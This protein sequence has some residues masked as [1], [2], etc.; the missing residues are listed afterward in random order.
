MSKQRITAL[1]LALGVTLSFSSALAA[2]GAVAVAAADRHNEARV[3]RAMVNPKSVAAGKRAAF[4]CLYCHGEE[5]SSVQENIPNLA[6]QNPVYLLTQIEKFGDGRRKDEFM[7][8][9]IKSLKEEDRVNLAVYYASLRPNTPAATDAALVETGRKRYQVTCAGCHGVDASGSHAVAR[10]AGQRVSYLTQAL[11]DYRSKKSPRTDPVMTT[12]A[13]NL[14][15]GDI[16]AIAA[17][18]STLK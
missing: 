2:P 17:Y 14:S 7:S 12:V 8:G 9:L 10:L 6:G 4:L 18:L 16:Q 11:S 15:R 1:G 3:Q 13:R 5:G